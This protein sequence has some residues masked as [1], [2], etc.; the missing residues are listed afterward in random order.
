MDQQTLTGLQEG[1]FTS[2]RVWSETQGQFI[3]I[4]DLLAS[5]ATG[6][7]SLHAGSG[8]VVTGGNGAYTIVNTEMGSQGAF[9]PQ[10]PPGVGIKGDKGDAIVAN[11]GPEGP[12]GYQE[13]PLCDRR[14][15]L[16]RVDNQS[17]GRRDRPETRASQ[18]QWVLLVR[19]LLRRPAGRALSSTL[20]TANRLGAPRSRRC[21]TA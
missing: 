16:A 6:V 11:G 8:L 2:L 7:T 9:G 15:T 12:R 5:G 10:G 18:V 20:S 21:A 13:S 14:G 19:L 1:D 17:W 3:G 4:I